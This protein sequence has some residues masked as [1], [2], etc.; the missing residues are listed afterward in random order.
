MCFVSGVSGTCKQ[1]KS[2][3]ASN[4]ANSTRRAPY[5]CSAWAFALRFVYSTF[6]LKPSAARR[7]TAPPIRPSPT[8]P[9]VLPCTSTPKSAG[10]MLCVHWP[11]FTHSAS[12]TTRRADARISENTVSAVDSV[13]TSGVCASTMP[14]RV[15]SATSNWSK[16]TEMVDKAFSRRAPSSIAGVIFTLEPMPPSASFKA[17]TNVSCC[18]GSICTTSACCCR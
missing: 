7:A 11:A 9:S 2:A 6:M 18:A 8:M 12:S 13:S 1:T 10:P 14:R 17:A 5:A 15:R 3:V 16:P 4:S